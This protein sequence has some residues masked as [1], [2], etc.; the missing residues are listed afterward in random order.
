[1]PSDLPGFRKNQCRVPRHIRIIAQTLFHITGEDAKLSI[2]STPG[3]D[4]H[5]LLQ[6]DLVDMQSRVGLKQF[7]QRTGSQRIRSAGISQICDRG[8]S[9]I[10]LKSGA[11]H[12][13][14]LFPAV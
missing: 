1:M 12:V 2:V 10:D 5:G 8:I 3:G 6:V 7:V 4:V 14:I 9:S 11:S 13:A